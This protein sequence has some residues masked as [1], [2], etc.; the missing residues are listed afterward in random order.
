MKRKHRVLSLLLALLFVA[1]TVF[2]IV[3]ALVYYY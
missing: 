2:T 1:G 3:F